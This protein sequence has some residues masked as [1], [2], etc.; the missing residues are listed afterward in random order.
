MVRH[1]Q[2]AAAAA[3]AAAAAAKPAA[4]RARSLSGGASG[5][6]PDKGNGDGVDG[7][8]AE[9]APR[10]RKA[11]ERLDPIAAPAGVS[12]RKGGSKST[13]RLGRASRLPCVHSAAPECGRAGVLM[14]FARSCA[15]CCAGHPGGRAPAEGDGAPGAGANP[16]AAGTTSVS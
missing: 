16:A 10:K 15:A 11:P 4:T 5:G 2:R 6:G 12:Q 3:T 7:I 8:L 13:V 9:F 1:E 14:L